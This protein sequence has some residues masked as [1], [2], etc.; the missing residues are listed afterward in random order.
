MRHN[1]SLVGNYE[2][3]F[4]KGRKYGSD[5]SGLKNV[6]LGGWNINSILQAHR[7]LAVTVYDGA[8]QSLQAT[9]SLGRPNSVCNGK[10]SGAGVNDAWIDINWFQ[11]APRG[12]FG[13]S[14][15]G[16]LVRTGYWKVDLGISKN[17]HFD[18]R[19]YLTLRIEAFNVFKHPNFAA[20]GR[21]RGFLQPNM[22]SAG[23]EATA[24]DPT[25]PHDAKFR[26]TDAGGENSLAVKG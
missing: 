7:G 13:D 26:A 19:R 14:G 12:Q 20:P 15:V 5:W 24:C 22:A 17:F 25:S 8:G 6:L 9:R 23:D 21:L 11:R 2:I 4:G 3:P 10:I 16:I 18:G 1:F